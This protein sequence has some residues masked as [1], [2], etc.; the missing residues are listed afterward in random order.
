MN[1]RF[2]N[3]NGNGL[4][5]AILHLVMYATG[6]HHRY[7]SFFTLYHFSCKEEQIG[8]CPYRP[9]TAAC[10]PYSYRRT[11][12]MMLKWIPMSAQWMWI[13]K[14]VCSCDIW[15]T[16]IGYVNTTCI[17][18]KV[19]CRVI[20]FPEKFLS[21]VSQ[22]FNNNELVLSILLVNE[23][24][25]LKDN[26]TKYHFKYTLAKDNSNELVNVMHGKSFTLCHARSVW[27][28]SYSANMFTANTHWKS[29]YG[30]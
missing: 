11:T 1:F 16:D 9:C 30:F 18:C 22:Q 3:A 20:F 25:S 14:V 6:M 27:C 26:I 13:V 24:N 4:E 7:K 12:V 29:I 8:I 5:A 10:V 17:M 2:W 28:L 21:W 23:E 15:Y 19:L